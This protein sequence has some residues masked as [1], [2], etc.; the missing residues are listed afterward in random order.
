VNWLKEILKACGDFLVCYY[1]GFKICKHF[2]L[3][4][5]LVDDKCSVCEASE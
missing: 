3:S 5:E 2:L 4:R 1:C